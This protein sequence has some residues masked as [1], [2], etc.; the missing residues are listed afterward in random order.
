MYCLRSLEP[1]STTPR[2]DNAANLADKVADFNGG[3]LFR[4]CFSRDDDRLGRDSRNKS[5]TE[6]KRVD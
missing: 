5:M 4:D 6:R 2:H 3:V 1:D